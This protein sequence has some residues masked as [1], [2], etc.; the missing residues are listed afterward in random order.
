MWRF[1]PGRKIRDDLLD[2]PSGLPPPNDMPL[3]PTSRRKG[4]VR[5]CLDHPWLSE[6]DSADY[7]SCH[8]GPENDQ[9]NAEEQKRDN[10]EHCGK[11]GHHHQTSFLEVNATD[12]LAQSG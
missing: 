9:L 4:I 8:E 5:P 7:A 1:P 2:E 12:A 11:Y 10:D 6:Q 3:Q